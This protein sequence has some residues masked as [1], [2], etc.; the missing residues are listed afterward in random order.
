MKVK[1]EPQLL[2]IRSGTFQRFICGDR[3]QEVTRLGSKTRPYV[4]FNIVW[5]L[6]FHTN[7]KTNLDATIVGITA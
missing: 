6:T 7:N 1:T 3:K 5:L 2:R 4:H